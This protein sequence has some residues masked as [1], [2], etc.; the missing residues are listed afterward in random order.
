MSRISVSLSQ[1]DG[2]MSSVYTLRSDMY[3]GV[4]NIK[5]VESTL[6][7][8]VKTTISNVEE[9]IDIMNSDI[10]AANEVISHNKYVL[11]KLKT[12]RDNL[13]KAEASASEAY[14]RAMSEQTRVNNSSSGSTDEEKK[15]HA[16]A[17]KSAERS[18][19][20]A[21]SHLNDIRRQIQAVQYRIDCVINN[22]NKL[23]SLIS[24]IV[25]NRGSARDFISDITT[26]LSN[27]KEKKKE[28]ETAA[29]KCESELNELDQ[30]A[31]NARSYIASALTKM[32]EACG[33]NNTDSIDV[34]GTQVIADTANL[35]EEMKKSVENF[36]LKQQQ[37]IH[38]FAD[39]MGD[40]ISM[41]TALVGKE[42]IDICKVQTK[43]FN[44]MASLLREAKKSLDG[45][46]K[47]Y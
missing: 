10:V 23:T 28:F 22:N 35:L 2:Y 21:E 44:E 33:H 40:D 14:R 17:V 26:K 43:N 31:K 8:K 47:I 32:S 25:S 16:D 30:K 24:V 20:S 39:E 1:I 5:S 29:G 46:L 38:I 3:N 15:A 27:F 18:V 4:S 41:H 45:Y 9:K 34:L 36:S 13:K 19:R 11:E 12:K 42:I 37:A 7:S 6:E